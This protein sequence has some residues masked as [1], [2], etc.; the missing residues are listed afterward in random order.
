MSSLI[1]KKKKSSSKNLKP[2]K[3]S[4]HSVDDMIGEPVK[5]TK[6][7]SNK[8]KKIKNK[9]LPTSTLEEDGVTDQA[10][11]VTEI[12][13]QTENE[14]GD[15][16]QDAMEKA[17]DQGEG[18]SEEIKNQAQE[19][20]DEAQET[21]DSEDELNLGDNDALSTMN[22]IMEYNRQ[23][24]QRLNEL[25]SQAQ[26]QGQEVSKQTVQDTV[27]DTYNDI[28][29]KYEKTQEGDGT[30]HSFELPLGDM[31]K[32][33]GNLNTEPLPDI[34]DSLSKKSDKDEESTVHGG[35]NEGNKISI[36]NGG[37]DDIVVKV[38]ATKTGITFS[39]HI[40]RD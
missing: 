18:V 27:Q 37:K 22:A 39:I 15:V 40:P 34:H 19:T 5:S 36:G 25:E 35:N 14:A 7:K 30:N 8:S 31:M 24:M 38:E 28:K 26:S 13:D 32:G 9:A 21:M 16:V 17:Q 3:S 6:K 23:L 4:K 10:K 20:I 12:T 2:K 11:N 1:E 33:Y 29:T